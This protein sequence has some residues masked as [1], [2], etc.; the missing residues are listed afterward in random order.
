MSEHRI[1][2]AKVGSLAFISHLDFFHCLIRA[3]KRARLPLRYS[4]G[5]NPRPKI[6]FALPLSVGME[7]LAE[8][9][10]ISLTEELSH[11]EVAERLRGALTDEFIVKSV[12]TPTVKMK[13]VAF[14]AYLVEFPDY[15]GD[16]DAIQK[17]LAAPPPVSKT[18]KSGGEKMLDIAAMMKEADVFVKEDATVLSLTLASSDNFF[19]NPDHVVSSIKSTGIPL[20]EDYKVTRTAILFDTQ[21]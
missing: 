15:I 4:E 1:T 16:V 21:N 14:A 6:S 20:P 8:I 11:S 10:D 3:L 17:A 19:L 18:T 2:F 7:G 5:F 12:E 13:H 9:V